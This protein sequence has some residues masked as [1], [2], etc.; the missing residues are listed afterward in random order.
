DPVRHA[1]PEAEEKPKLMKR[2]HIA[3]R[4]R[5]YSRRTEK[6]YAAWIRRFILFHGKRHP[7]EMG[8]AELESFLS[9]LATDRNV[10]ASTQNQ[11]LAALLFLY[12]YVLEQDVPWLDNIVRAKKPARLPV[13]LTRAEVVAVLAQL[14][15][16]PRLVA[17]LLYGAGLRL[18]EALQL[19]V[20]DVDFGA[21]QIVIRSGKGNR[22]RVALLPD[23]AR[24]ELEAH[25]RRTRLFHQRD[26]E[27][28]LGRVA[29]PNAL[30]A[31][32]PNAD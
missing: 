14:E 11:A 4:T 3:L 28:G 25:L 19:R 7:A 16:I 15:G 2:L 10:A 29:I 23:I 1:G 12:K 26:V 8:A 21:R 17:L 6:A 20:K 13:V 22:E 9:S 5:H 31:K 24:D 32:Y 30:S 27:H 18:L